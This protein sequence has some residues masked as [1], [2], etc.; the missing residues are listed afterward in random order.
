MEVILT[1]FFDGILAA[2]S[3]IVTVG[4]YLAV[5]KEEVAQFLIAQ[6]MKADTLD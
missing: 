5:H 1:A 6:F 2:N 4:D 3:E